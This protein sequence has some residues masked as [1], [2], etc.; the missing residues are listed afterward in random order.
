MARLRTSLASVD[1][2]TAY[3]FTIARNESARLLRKKWRHGRAMCDAAA[4]FCEA[5][6]DD[7][8]SRGAAEMVTAALAQL[9]IEQRE[10]VELRV[11]AG[12]G[13]REIAEVTGLPQ[14]T[15][16]TRYRTAIGRLRNWF[17]RKCHE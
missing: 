1:N 6:S 17:V 8:Q 16:A 3:I 12:L 7:F 11:N 5:T 14:G 10:I 2:V 9:T 4:L 13:L 15:V